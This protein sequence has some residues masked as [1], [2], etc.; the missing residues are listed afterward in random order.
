MNAPTYNVIAHE[1]IQNPMSI[2]RWIACIRRSGN[3]IKCTSRK[4]GSHS[5]RRSASQSASLRFRSSRVSTRRAAS[6]A[7]RKNERAR[8]GSILALSAILKKR[9][10]ERVCFLEMEISKRN[11]I[12][13]LERFYNAHGKRAIKV[14]CHNRKNGDYPKLV[15]DLRKQWG[16]WIG[17]YEGSH[18]EW[19]AFYLC[20]FTNKPNTLEALFQLGIRPDDPHNLLREAYSRCFDACAK[21]LLDHG[22]YH[23]S[24]DFIHPDW[25]VEFMA[26]RERIRS[27]SIA[28]LRALKLI[29]M[30]RDVCVL[31][32]RPVW[33]A[34]RAH[35]WSCW[36]RKSWCVLA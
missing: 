11:R 17:Y 29:G 21:V 31:I 15:I 25:V 1:R 10:S 24:S 23:V 34:R 36:E 4:S 35:D 7:W 33:T 26:T 6:T 3:M 28:L 19:S 30:P 8:D 2:P 14:W 5:L 12:H 22:Y 32:A 18:P 20:V 13:P 27:A 16:A 9:P